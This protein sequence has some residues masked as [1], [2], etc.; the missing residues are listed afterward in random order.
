ME[1]WAV[2]LN[3]PVAGT[4]A[5]LGSPACLGCFTLLRP[6]TFPAESQQ[7]WVSHNVID[8]LIDLISLSPLANPL[9]I[10][11]SCHLTPAC[12]LLLGGMCFSSNRLWHSCSCE[13]TSFHGDVVNAVLDW[14]YN[15]L[16]Q[17]ATA[18]KMDLIILVFG[19]LKLISSSVENKFGGEFLY[20]LVLST[21]R[22][23]G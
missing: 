22:Y 9:T 14:V 12:H 13:C 23:F 15:T 20:D 2:E 11:A 19:L 6:L 8:N 1:K 4:W 21:L 18:C 3:C 10:F 17:G 5:V 16:T 7:V